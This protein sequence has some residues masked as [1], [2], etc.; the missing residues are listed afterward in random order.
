MLGCPMLTPKARPLIS[1][2]L[3]GPQRRAHALLLRQVMLAEPRGAGA[4]AADVTMGLIFN[5]FAAFACTG[6]ATS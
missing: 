2:V 5:V 4:G 1:A 6:A 3:S